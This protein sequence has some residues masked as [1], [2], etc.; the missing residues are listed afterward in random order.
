MN[1]MEKI[2]QICSG[3]PFVKGKVQ[4]KSQKLQLEMNLQIWFVCSD[5]LEDCV[6][7]L[8]EL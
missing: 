1:R 6:K 8:L 5:L 2:C 3:L 4:N 7:I